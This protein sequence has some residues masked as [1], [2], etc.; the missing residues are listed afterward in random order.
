MNRIFFKSALVVAAV[1]STAGN[2]NGQTINIAQSGDT[3]VVTVSNPTKYLLLP[4]EE[5]Q[6]DARVKLDTGSPA[7]TWMD[8]RLAVGKTDY[9]VPF[10]LKASGSPAVVKILN[11]KKGALCLSDG[12]MKL[13][14]TWDAANTDYYRPAYHHTPAYG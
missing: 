12:A 5:T 8:V 3:A 13:S 1:C 11:L 10:K 14:D 2:A 6:P 7:D 4:V 9:Y